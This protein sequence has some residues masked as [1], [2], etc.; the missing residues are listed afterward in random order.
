MEQRPST[1]ESWAAVKAVL[2]NRKQKDARKR[3]EDA[4]KKMEEAKKALE[5]VQS[6]AALETVQLQLYT[7]THMAAPPD[8]FLSLKQVVDEAQDKVKLHKEFLDNHTETFSK[9]WYDQSQ[10]RACFYSF[11]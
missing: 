7:N 5:T 3:M 8:D 10:D 2:D 9:S 4:Q 1:P 6:S 11:E